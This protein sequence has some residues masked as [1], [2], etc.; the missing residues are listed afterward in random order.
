[1]KLC[2]GCVN[3]HRCKCAFLMMYIETWLALCTLWGSLVG[4]R[5]VNNFELISVTFWCHRKNLVWMDE[6]SYNALEIFSSASHPS[7]FKWTNAGM[8]EGFSIYGLFNRCDSRVGSRYMRYMLHLIFY[9]YFRPK[10]WLFWHPWLQKRLSGGGLV[11]HSWSAW[12][13]MFLLSL[14]EPLLVTPLVESFIK[15]K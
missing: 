12:S 11:F 9:Q 2:C 1:M 6:E 4:K 3:D 10:L 13:W 7:V 15:G 8:R 5:E 14:V